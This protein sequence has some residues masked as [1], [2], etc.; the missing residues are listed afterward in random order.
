MNMPAIGLLRGFASAIG[1]LGT[2]AYHISVKYMSL[3]MTGLWSILYECT[4][5]G[6]AYVAVLVGSPSSTASLVVL[7]IGVCASRIG[8]WVFDIA[9]TQLQ[10]ECIPDGFRLR[11]GGVQTSLNAFCTLISF[12]VGFLV[13]DPT[14]FHIFVAAAFISVALAAK[15]Y[16]Y[17]MMK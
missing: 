14:D 7:I 1:L 9:V 10:Q 13:P 2:C 12:T 3:G 16:A 4:C 8:L 17:G 5:L 6:M 11:V 15:V